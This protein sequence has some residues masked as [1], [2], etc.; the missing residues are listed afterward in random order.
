MVNVKTALGV[1]VV[2]IIAYLALKSSSS[3]S[4]SA[5][6]SNTT[7]LPEINNEQTTPPIVENIIDP[8]IK[9]IRAEIIKAQA[10]IKTLPITAANFTGSIKPSKNTLARGGIQRTSL[11]RSA[12]DFQAGKTSQCDFN[13]QVSLVAAQKAS[14]QNKQ[15]LFAQDF[16]KRQNQSINLL[17]N[18]R[19]GL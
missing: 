6:S 8:R 2:G 11:T 4:V 19:T 3:V 7:L 18:T 16:I 1:A 13:C 14:N 5:S 10:F 17:N 9:Q 12:A 15:K